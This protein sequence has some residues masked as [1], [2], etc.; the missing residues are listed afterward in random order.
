MR[1]SF[2]VEIPVSSMRQLPLSGRDSLAC[3]M[4]VPGHKV[5]CRQICLGILGLANEIMKWPQDSAQ[6]HWNEN[7]SIFRY[8]N[9]AFR[10]VAPDEIYFFFFLME[11]RQSLSIYYFFLLL[12]I[13]YVAKVKRET[14]SGIPNCKSIYTINMF[15]TAAIRRPWDQALNYWFLRAQLV[16]LGLY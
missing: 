1:C 10:Q 11:N 15:S 7:N 14:F 5:Q 9:W 13:F 2:F 8:K 3:S 12:T 4:G 16:V 6:V